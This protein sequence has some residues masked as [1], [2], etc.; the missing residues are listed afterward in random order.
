MRDLPALLLLALAADGCWAQ[1]WSIGGAG[2][3]SFYRDVTITNPSGSA[4]AGFGPRVALSG[5]LGEDVLEHFGGEFRYAFLDGDSELK[6][7]GTEANMDAASHAL[8]FD[9]LAY[10]TGRK[11]RLRP[12]VAA[13]GGF[14]Y[15]TGTGKEDPTQPLS[16]FAFLTHTNQIE[17]LVSFGGGVKAPVSDH[18]LVRL[19]FRDYATPFPD[20]VIA[21]APGAKLHGWLHDFVVMV[22]VDWKIR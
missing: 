11:A 15:Y 6:S 10:A 18:W 3:F 8:H 12:F 1:S 22:G 4:N 19:D 17:G 5:V 21:P 20:K 13:G 2:G 9:F 14:K 7:H 16:D